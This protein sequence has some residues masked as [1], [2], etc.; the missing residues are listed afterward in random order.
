M[1]G[2]LK[3]TSTSFLDVSSVFGKRATRL[4]GIVSRNEEGRLELT[5]RLY[6]AVTETEHIRKGKKGPRYNL[7]KNAVNGEKYILDVQGYKVV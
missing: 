1:L 6:W 4:R 7:N 5:T 2:E 3:G